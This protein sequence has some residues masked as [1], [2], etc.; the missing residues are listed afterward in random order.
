MTGLAIALRAL[1]W[2]IGVGLVL[3][4][5]AEPVLA[6]G[7]TVIYVLIVAAISVLIPRV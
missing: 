3:W 5:L 6:A 7:S 1:A 4:S 2:A